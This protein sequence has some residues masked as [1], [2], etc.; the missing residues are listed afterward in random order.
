MLAQV[1][2]SANIFGNMG[3]GR[4]EELGDSVNYFANTLTERL[5]TA[6]ANQ[7]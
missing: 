1:G 5:I 4:G 6:N 7:Q 3:L 2:Q